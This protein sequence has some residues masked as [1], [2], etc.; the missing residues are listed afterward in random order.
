VHELAVEKKLKLL[1]YSNSHSMEMAIN[2][3]FFIGSKIDM[4]RLEKGF[5]LDKE[6]DNLKNYAKEIEYAG[7]DFLFIDEMDEKI[8]LQ[9][10]Q[11]MHTKGNLDVVMIDLG[12]C[13]DVC[14]TI[15]K[16]LLIKKIKELAVSLRV[17]F[18]I[19]DY[20]NS[21]YLSPLSLRKKLFE[22]Y[23]YSHGLK[24]DKV[25]FVNN[26]AKSGKIKLF[27][28]KNGL[29]VNQTIFLRFNRFCGKVDFNNVLT[30]IRDL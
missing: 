13:N 10:C 7:K 29:N 27:V 3:L 18:F 20:Q 11:L 24:A 23:S 8:L 30:L 4:D 17:S 9:K 21:F 12:A 22:I 6:W 14:N 1:L 2:F 5:L 16:S 15:K 28:F 26:H 25:L 19:F